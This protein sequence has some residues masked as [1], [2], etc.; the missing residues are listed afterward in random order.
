MRYRWIDGFNAT[1]AEWNRIEDLL[2]SRGW[3]S[4]TRSTSRILVAED[5]DGELMGFLVLQLYPHTEPLWVRPSARGTD[6]AAELS[7]RMV[8]FLIEIKARG[9]MVIADSPFAAKLCE[10][11]GMRKLEKPVYVAGRE[12]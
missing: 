9:W 12:D 6:V 10:E 3:S 4:L 7:N 1:D 11:R 2:A 8:D 5:D